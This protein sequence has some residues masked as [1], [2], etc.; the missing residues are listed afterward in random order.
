MPRKKHDV[1]VSMDNDMHSKLILISFAQKY[2][3]GKKNASMSSIIHQ[4]LLEYFDNHKDEM[5]EA[6]KIINEAWR[7]QQ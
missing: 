5:D 7:K 3:M 1:T 4:A 2:R 6:I